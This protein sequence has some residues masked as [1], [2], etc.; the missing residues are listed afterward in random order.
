MAPRGREGDGE[1]KY[2][3]VEQAILQVM[4]GSKVIGKLCQPGLSTAEAVCLQVNLL[5]AATRRCASL[6][7]P[8]K[9]PF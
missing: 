5:S 9:L 6:P 3:D 7:L 8:C 4:D 1:Q 2:H